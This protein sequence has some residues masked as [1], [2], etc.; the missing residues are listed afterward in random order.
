MA[1]NTSDN[2]A[3]GSN[4]QGEAVGPQEED[5]EN[6]STHETE[7]LA[8]KNSI[9]KEVLQASNPQTLAQYLGNILGP[10][11]NANNAATGGAQPGTKRPHPLK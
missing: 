3:H 5:P 11:Q 7:L 1:E 8:R 10:L 9:V 4:Q 2:A 6:T